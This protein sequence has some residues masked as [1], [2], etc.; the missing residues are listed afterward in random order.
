M[1]VRIKSHM[2]TIFPLRITQAVALFFNVK[3]IVRENI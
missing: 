2:E 1:N 3:E